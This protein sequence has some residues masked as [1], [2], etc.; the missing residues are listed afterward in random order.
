MEH[1]TQIRIDFL[2]DGNYDGEKLQ[3]SLNLVFFAQGM[4]MLGA[5][6]EGMDD[7]YKELLNRE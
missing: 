3:E 7:A 6:F 4:E 2:H 1:V 5:D